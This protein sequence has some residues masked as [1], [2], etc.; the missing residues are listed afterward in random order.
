MSNNSDNIKSLEA[1]LTF[2]G[3]DKAVDYVKQHSRDITSD[4]IG[5]MNTM[6]SED[7]VT[8]YN[9]SYNK[10]DN[11]GSYQFRVIFLSCTC[12]YH[13]KAQRRQETTEGFL[14]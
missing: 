7:Y 4:T 13:P 3:L 1:K 2:F 9:N 6:L 8:K 5:V 10:S 11:S 14:F 12:I